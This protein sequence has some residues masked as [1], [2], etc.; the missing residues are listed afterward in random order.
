MRGLRGTDLHRHR[1]GVGHRPGDRGPALLEEGARVMGAD[2]VDPAGR[3]RSRATDGGGRWAFT[4]S[5]SPTRPP[6]PSWCVAAVAFGGARR[7]AGQ[8][9]RRGRRRPGPH[10]AG[11]GVGPR[12]RGEPDRHLPHRQARHRARCSRQPAR[13]GRPARL[14]GDAGQHRG[15]R[16]HGRRQRLQRLE[17]RRRAADQE[18][19][20]RLR[21]P[22]HPGQR[23]LPR[24][25]RDPDD[26]RPSSVPAWRTALADI[27]REHKLG[28]RMGRPEEIASV[29]GRSCSR[30]TRR[31]VTG[32]ALAVDGGYTAGRDHGVTEM[33]GL[34]GPE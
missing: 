7:R 12:D 16:G 23:H 3:A 33:L 20:D 6:S 5:T 4:R 9:G 2:L 27:L 22:R 25:H 19:G 8:R 26:R 18:H 14:G 28:R 29:G 1:C 11:R 34:S 24:L 31:F 13:D 15:A 10:A 32:H 21:R 30:T 17:G